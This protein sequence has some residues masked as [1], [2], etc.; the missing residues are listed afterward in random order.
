V[1]SKKINYEGVG[2][3]P[4]FKVLATKNDVNKKYDSV[5]EIGLLILENKIAT[6]DQKEH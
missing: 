5:L 4:D 1:S 3:T 6:N 2:I